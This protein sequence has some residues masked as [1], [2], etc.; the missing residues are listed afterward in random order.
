MLC[1]GVA[2]LSFVFSRLSGRIGFFLQDRGGSSEPPKFVPGVWAGHSLCTLHT[3]GS[4]SELP[5]AFQVLGPP[6]LNLALDRKHQW[7][8]QEMTYI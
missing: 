3:V 7:V 4:T 2:R 1:T 6:F 8:A 5:H